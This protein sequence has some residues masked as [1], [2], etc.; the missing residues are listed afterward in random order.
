[1]GMYSRGSERMQISSNQGGFLGV[2]VHYFVTPMQITSNYM[3]MYSTH[4]L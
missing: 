3:Y 1:M 2:Y 4:T